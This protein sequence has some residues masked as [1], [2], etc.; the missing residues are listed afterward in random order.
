MRAPL[1]A[2]NPCSPV[3]LNRRTGNHIVYNNSGQP[4]VSIIMSVHIPGQAVVDRFEN[5]FI[6]WGFGAINT[7][8]QLS[9]V[10]GPNDVTSDLAGSKPGY[11]VQFD[12]DDIAPL[13]PHDFVTD[14]HELINRDGVD[15][16]VADLGWEFTGF[17]T[18]NGLAVAAFR[19]DNGSFVLGH[20]ED[21]RFGDVVTDDDVIV[22]FMDAGACPCPFT[23]NPLQFISASAY[24][25]SGW[26][27]LRC[28]CGRTY[29]HHPDEFHCEGTHVGNPLNLCGTDETGLVHASVNPK[30]FWIVNLQSRRVDEYLELDVTDDPE[31]WL[32]AHD[33]VFIGA[34]HA[35][36]KTLRTTT[37]VEGFREQ[38]HGTEFIESWFQQCPW[39]ELDEIL[40]F[41]D[42]EAFARSLDVPAKKIN[43]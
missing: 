9:D 17:L 11:E 3:C 36:E 12:R 19:D 1:T 27:E 33:G 35:S 5:G 13:S 37:I 28:R 21:S 43:D 39:S 24:S 22:E 16:W 32:W 6:G 40:T 31:S 26:K 38:G 30:A 2:N 20:V 14:T 15:G 18:I 4:R 10:A 42:T 8:D 7:Y 23:E 41:D 29:T 25:R 34:L